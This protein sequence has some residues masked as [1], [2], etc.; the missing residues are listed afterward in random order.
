MKKQLITFYFLLVS[1]LLSLAQTE[2]VK[3]IDGSS[4][5]AMK[6][7]MQKMTATMTKEDKD[8]FV[9]A[10]MYV[11][12]GKIFKE[13]VKEDKILEYLDGKTAEEL[14]NDVKDK[15]REKAKEEYKELK[16]KKAEAE[17]HKEILNQI[18]ISEYELTTVES[19]G[20]TVPALSATIENNTP[21]DLY[22]VYFKI[23]EKNDSQG[24]DYKV[25]LRITDKL[26]PDQSKTFTEAFQKFEGDAEEFLNNKDNFVVKVIEIKDEQWKT[27]YDIDY[28]SER[29][30]SKL[31]KITKEFPE[32]GKN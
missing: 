24:E 29:D 20:E 13:D 23:T 11:V 15:K 26:K 22:L 4:E 12:M 32:L 19:F 8:E 17:K 31:E 5:E 16:K 1:T 14:I 18:K 3:T 10:Y 7:S 9:D 2:Q 30:A 6:T 21:V 25:S 28:F 27:I